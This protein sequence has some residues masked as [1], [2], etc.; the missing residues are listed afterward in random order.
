MIKRVR[1]LCFVLLHLLAFTP[2]LHAQTTDQLKPKIVLQTLPYGGIEVAAWTPDDRYIITAGDASRLVL[3]WDAQTGYIVDRIPLPG[4]SSRT[5]TVSKRLVAMWISDDGAK[6]SISAREVDASEVRFEGRV[7][8]GVP[9]VTYH[10]DLQSRTFLMSAVGGALMRVAIPDSEADKL[11]DEQRKWAEQDRANSEKTRKTRDELIARYER[12]ATNADDESE[13]LPLPASHDGKRTLHRSPDGLVIKEA[14]IDDIELKLERNLRF[15]DAALSDDGTVLAMLPEPAPQ[16]KGGTNESHIE[17]FDTTTGQFLNRITLQGEYYRVQWV[18]PEKLLATGTPENGFGTDNKPATRAALIDS[19]SA[20]ISEWIK[21]QC[22][23]RP[24]KMG[25]FFGA[26]LAN[27]SATG[28]NDV[29]LKRY[30]SAQR[31]WRPFGTIPMEDGAKIVDIA[32]SYTGN[33]L[34]AVTV[35]ADGITHFNVLDANTGNLIK[36]KLFDGR[37]PVSKVIMFDD[38][39]LFVSSDSDSATWGIT[40]DDW[41]PMPITSANTRLIETNASVVALAGEG[42]DLISLMDL[43]T[44][45][46]LPSINFGRV[47]AGGFLAETPIFWALSA[48]D[49]LR[50]WNTSTSDWRELI[51]TYFFSDQGFVAVTPEGRYDTNQ[52]PD[53]SLFRWLVPDRPFQSLG[54]Q[55]FMRDYFTPG[56]AEAVMTCTYFSDCDT[57]LPPLKPIADLNRVIPEV[58]ITNVEPGSTPDEAVIS[59]VV[60]NGVDPTAPAGKNTSGVYDLRLFRDYRFADQKPN[61]Q[62]LED[63]S[64]LEDWRKVNVLVDDDDAPNDGVFHKTFTVLVPTAADKAKMLFTAYAFNEDRVKSETAYSEDYVR[65]AMTPRK[66]RAF[67]VSIGIDDYTEARLKLNYAAADA[68]QM[69]RQ[70]KNFPGYEMRNLVVAA[71]PGSKVQPTADSI[72]LIFAM[73]AG[74]DREEGLK[75]LSEAGIDGSVLDR[76]M[77]DD[78]VIFTFSGHGWADPQRNFYLIPSDGEWSDSADEPNAQSLVN[79]NEMT[80]WLRVMD[81]SEIVLIIDACHAGASVQ[82]ANFKAGPMGDPGLGQLAYDKGIRILVATQAEDVALEDANLRHGLL[83]YALTGKDE[84]FAKADGILD[85]VP[86]RKISLDEWITYPLDRLPTMNDDKR[87]TGNDDEQNI[88]FRF[89]GRTIKPV[90]KVQQPTLFDYGDWSKVILKAKSK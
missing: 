34:T 70:L 45:Q 40:D 18:A 39:M 17:L 87:V 62:D 30:D 29:G 58:V 71:T 7:R 9:T 20:S 41:A 77:P 83:T 67:V 68:Q 36:Q 15:R 51:T 60:T 37:G 53:S 65:P 16:T 1:A 64:A 44:G 72:N 32:I 10:L 90:K 6:A 49:G 48:H 14:S 12:G 11:R 74:F 42:D 24:T 22:F 25:V 31:K 80:M 3:I 28:G 46:A 50:L 84:A 52:D 38:D 59:V 66:P 78:V 26:G 69:E 55:T 21:P 27:C 19:G 43:K 63:Q 23:M 4:G 35:T 86:D 88:S 13:L 61:A 73:L 5:S 47:L 76:S 75:M 82:T 81:A 33:A 57:S 8:S 85:G 79:M 2:S 56:L 54:S 89:P